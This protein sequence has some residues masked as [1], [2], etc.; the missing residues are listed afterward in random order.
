MAPR[1]ELALGAA[2]FPSA[3]W[4]PNSPPYKAGAVCDGK[5]R[6]QR[7]KCQKDPVFSHPLQLRHHAE[8]MQTGKLWEDETLPPAGWGID[9]PETKAAE[10]T[11]DPPPLRPQRLRRRKPLWEGSFGLITPRIFTPA[12]HSRAASWTPPSG[13][14]LFLS[15]PARTCCQVCSVPPQRPAIAQS[16]F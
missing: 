8:P 14:P 15:G 3:S 4:G 11:F 7:G 10:R 12:G 6:K 16:H 13:V 2:C 1:P 5:G 9:D